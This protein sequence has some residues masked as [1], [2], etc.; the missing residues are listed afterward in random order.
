MESFIFSIFFQF[1]SVYFFQSKASNELKVVEVISSVKNMKDFW[2][3][4][5]VL[6]FIKFYFISKVEYPGA[7]AY[8]SKDYNKYFKYLALLFNVNNIV[9]S[10]ADNQINH[11]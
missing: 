4:A 8:N 7:I 1:F 2:L 6:V 11:S 10:P 5:H 3:F 9:F